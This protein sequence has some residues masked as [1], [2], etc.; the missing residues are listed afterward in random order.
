MDKYRGANQVE[1]PTGGG[2]LKSSRVIK[3]A[4]VWITREKLWINSLSWGEMGKIS[5]RAIIHTPHIWRRLVE[6]PEY[7]GWGF[8]TVESCYF[9][10]D[11][12]LAPRWIMFEEKNPRDM[13]SDCFN[14]YPWGL[15][16]EFK[17]LSTYPQPLLRLRYINI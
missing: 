10:P 3:S 9:Y 6:P 15:F 5:K 2:A 12:I 17:T 13:G 4:F 14:T 1:S 16:F 8:G 7:N 11:L